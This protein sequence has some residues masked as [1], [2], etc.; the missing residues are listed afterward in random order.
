MEKS[1]S[2]LKW[3]LLAGSA[4]F[5]GVAVAHMF[6]V[7]I[8][9]LFVYFDVPSHTYQDRI[10][11]F[12]A[13]GWS[14]FL[15]TASTDPVRQR[16]LVKAILVSGAAAVVGLSVV[17]SA[18]DFHALS[19]STSVHVFWIETLGLFGYLVWLAVFHLRS[20]NV[21]PGQPFETGEPRSFRGERSPPN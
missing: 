1:A 18:T 9:G 14:A 13:F 21:A 11:S 16:S 3:S 5:L 6:G 10:I 7:K 2:V 15:F 20:R 8:P 4:Y 12:L 19:P 17:N